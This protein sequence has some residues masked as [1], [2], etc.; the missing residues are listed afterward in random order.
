LPLIA[1]RGGGPAPLTRAQRRVW[2]FGQMNPGARA[3]QHAGLV[4]IEGELDPG[5]LRAAL[6]QLV[7][8]PEAWRSSVVVRDGEP[9]QLVHDDIPMPFEELDL[10]GRPQAELACAVR[11]RARVSIDPEQAP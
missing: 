2:L 9:L 8:R 1:P 4:R 3:Y 5:R 11:E 7:S 6:E 10:R